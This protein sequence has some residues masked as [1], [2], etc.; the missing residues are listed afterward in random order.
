V[1]PAAVHEDAE[2]AG[3]GRIGCDDL[4]VGLALVGRGV[5]AAVL[6]DAGFRP[7]P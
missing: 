2:E 3:G 1:S 4:L 7:A 5:A 6:K